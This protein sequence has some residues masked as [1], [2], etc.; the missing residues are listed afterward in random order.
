MYIRSL[1]QG[2]PGLALQHKELEGCRSKSYNKKK[3]L[4][5]RLTDYSWKLE[6]KAII[7]KSGV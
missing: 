2:L 1:L 4:K 3:L 5:L 7:L 6:C